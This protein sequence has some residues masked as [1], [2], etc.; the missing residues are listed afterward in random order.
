VSTIQAIR[1]AATG[2]PEVLTLQTVDLGPPGPGEIRIR[3]GAIGVNFIDTYHRTGLYPISLP[4]GLG[5]EAAG[6][7]EAIGDGVTDFKVGDRAAYCTGPIGAYADAANVPAARCVPVPDGVSDAVAA[8]AL[9]KG[10]TAEFLIRRTFPVQPDQTV[11]FHAAAGGVG[12]IA[13]QWLKHI[14]ATVI[15]TVGSAEKAALVRSYGCDHVILYRDEPV[16]E[17]VRKI[18]GGAGVPVVYD[19]VGKDTLWSSLD[20]LSIR[21]LFISFG[22]ASGP[23]DPIPALELSRRGSLFMTRPTLFHYV[24]TTPEL[25]HAARDLFQLIADGIITVE[26][27]ARF[28]LSEAG[29]AHRALE[30]RATT[31]STVLEPGR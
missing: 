12:L 5:L 14:G 13:L 3:H 28:G 9:L 19:S 27:G 2:G 6:T 23:P 20:S 10:L 7:V 18:T 17:A 16:A 24:A 1:V 30:A 22:N 11:L 31:G 21:G 15:G 4:S 25:R 8:A 29:E 26:I